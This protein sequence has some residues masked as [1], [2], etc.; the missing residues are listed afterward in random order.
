MKNFKLI[1]LLFISSIIITSCSDDNSPEHIHEEEVI[2]TMKVVLT[3]ETGDP[4]TLE[5]D[6]EEPEIT[7]G[8]LMANT[9]YSAVITLLNENESPADNI[10]LEVI[11]E[12]EEHQFFYTTSGIVSTFTY[13]D[14][15]AD[16][17]PLGVKFTVETGAI[18]TGSY[19]I[20]LKHEPTKNGDNV[21]DGD[22]TN[23]G[24]ETDIEVVFPITV[25]N[26][27]P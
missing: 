15:D 24:G 19:T 1:A 9:T 2:T 25:E 16:G 26:P 12:A 27:I 11:E 7:G 21:A 5:Y 13:T 8:T 23:A 3:P 18:G 10:T 14:T 17:N 4:V 22:M 6:H 20:I